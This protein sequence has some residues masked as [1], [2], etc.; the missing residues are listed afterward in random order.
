MNPVT[1]VLCTCPEAEAQALADQL[2]TEKL[3]ACVNFIG[4]VRS[5]YWWEGAI[6]ESTETLLVMKT[7]GPLATRLRE[8]INE[9]HSYDVP[10]VLE[11]HADA[12]LPAYMAWVSASCQQ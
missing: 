4:P 8:R 1:L 12:G 2:L 11:F 3:V 10:E 5:R 7:A 6:D 9:L